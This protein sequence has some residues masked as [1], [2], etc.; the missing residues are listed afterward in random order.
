MARLNVRMLLNEPTAAAVCFGADQAEDDDT[1]TYAVYDL[2]GGTFDVSI[3]QVSRGNV[4][5]VGTGGDSR[6]GGSDFDDRITDYALQ[7]IRDKHGVDLTDDPVV[8]PRVKRA[9]E[10]AKRELSSA[11]AAQLNLPFLTPTLSVNVP[12]NRATFEKRIHDL[13]QRSLVCLDEAIESARESNGIER[14]DIEQVLLVGGSTLIACIR[15]LLAAHL[16]LDPKDVRADIKPQEVVARGAGMVAREYSPSDS[17][18]GSDSPDGPGELVEDSSEASRG[19]LVLQDVTSHTLG[20]AVNRTEMARI[21]RKDSRIPIEVTQDHFI[22]AG[23]S[24]W[25]DVMIFQGESERAWDNALIGRLPIELPE[26]RERGYYK[27]AVTFALDVHGLLGVQVRCLNDDQIWKTDVQCSVRSTS[28]QIEQSSKH[29]DEVEAGGSDAAE[30]PDTRVVDESVP[31]PPGR[32]PPPPP[33]VAAPEPTPPPPP[34][35]TP[36]EFRSTLRR[37]Y[38][39]LPQLEAPE[40]TRLTAKYL[41]V[42]AAVRDDS[43]DLED[44]HASRG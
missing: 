12:I 21:L 38:K 40:R 5:V 15:Q 42:L 1:H 17:F 23:G 13:L 19:A 4:G 31:P 14:D 27:F 25:I 22:N 30:E 28:A 9:A 32:L 41:E 43:P 11:N 44:L 16:D 35:D 6:L 33:R 18:I 8:R 36:V 34:G 24:K 37:V 39:L 7:W 20:I 10:V 26:E 29:L 3:V 2:G